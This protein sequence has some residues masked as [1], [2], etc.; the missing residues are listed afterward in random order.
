V[1]VSP[2]ITIIIIIIKNL[3]EEVAISTEKTVSIITEK[4]ITLTQAKEP[5]IARHTVI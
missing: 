4:Q 1:V 5:I 3:I 2:I